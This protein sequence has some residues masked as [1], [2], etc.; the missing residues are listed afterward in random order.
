MNE[1]K[2]IWVIFI[3]LIIERIIE[4]FLPDKNK[5]KGEVSS[6]WLFYCMLVSGILIYI[7]AI[8]EFIFLVKKINIF[9]TIIGSVLI[10][11]RI[12]LKVWA[13]KT[14]GKFWSIQIEIREDQKLIKEGPYKYVRHPSY[15]S[16][17]IE[18]TAG[19]LIFNSY[20]TILF[21]WLVYIPFLITRIYLEEKELLKKFG[22]E[23]EEYRRS[24][25][26]LLPIKIFKK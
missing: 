8:S 18:V 10:I 12:I 22:K 13:V 17:M 1:R 11:F 25:P 4:T 3:I 16:T 19:P 21:V 15:L 9:I 2:I 14:L 5:Q 20:Y 23:Y 7:C 26:L 6:K 24:V